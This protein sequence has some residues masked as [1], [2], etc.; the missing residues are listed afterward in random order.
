MKLHLKKGAVVNLMVAGN[1]SHYITYGAI[2]N[3]TE[4]EVVLAIQDNVADS[5]IKERNNGVSGDHID[6]SV[7][8]DSLKPH[9]HIDREKIFGWNYMTIDYNDRTTLYGY[10]LRD[11]LKN[12][13]NKCIHYY[14]DID[15]TCPGS[16]E[17]LE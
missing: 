2:V 17:Y 15:G 16:G 3:I 10:V 13:P 9:I 11:E 5:T 7:S 1:N 12:Y 14:Y 6:R 4:N 8:V